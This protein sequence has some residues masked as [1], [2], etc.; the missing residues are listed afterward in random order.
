MERFYDEV[1]KSLAGSVSRRE[2]LR[3][4]G[5]ALAG[6]ALGQFGLGTAWAAGATTCKTFCN[7][8]RTTKQRNQCLAACRACR[9]NVSRLCGSCGAYACCGA[10]TSCCGAYCADLGYDF[11]NCGGCGAACD[12]PGPW[13]YGACVEGSC[14]YDCVDGAADCGDGMCTWLGDDPDNCG[15][16]GNVCGG[17]APYCIQGVCTGAGPCFGGQ[18][19]CDGV[20]RE[21]QLDP[22]NCGAC[23]VECGPGENCAGGLCQPAEPF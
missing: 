17:S 6:V 20:C 14:V 10:G 9:N 1:S 21:I 23:G 13:E 18:V 4:M 3:R 12:D 15:A 5:A 19:L 2:S 7:R 16:C 8:C 22:S 11:D